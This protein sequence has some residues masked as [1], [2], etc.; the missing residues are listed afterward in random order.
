MKSLERIEKKLDKES[1][2][3]KIGSRRIPEKKRRSRSVSR[4]HHHS[5]NTP[6]RR[7]TEVQ[8]HLLPEST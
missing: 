5:Q 1:D 6:I 4:H 3:R 2:S 7:H 8:A